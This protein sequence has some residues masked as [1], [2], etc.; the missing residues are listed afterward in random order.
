M[1]TA[2][3]QNVVF[4]AEPPIVLSRSVK[5]PPFIAVCG[6]GSL[7]RAD[8]TDGWLSVPSREDVGTPVDV[9]ILDTRPELLIGDLNIEG[10]AGSVPVE[11]I[12]SAS[13]E[14]VRLLCK[15]HDPA[16]RRAA[17]ETAATWKLS[18]GIYHGK[19]VPTHTII[20]VPR[21]SRRGG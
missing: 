9:R 17:H 15:S 12:V 5:N 3:E 21:S 8:A 19:A 10:A 14:V 1:L 16:T 2:C 20:R 18:P 7:P 4:P 13:G 11:V 6:V